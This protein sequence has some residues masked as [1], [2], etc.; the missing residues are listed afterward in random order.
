MSHEG[1]NHP[2]AQ[3]VSSRI[4]LL[5]EY[6]PDS[7]GDRM[8]LRLTACDPEA[9]WYE[10]RAE[11][12]QWMRNVVG[13]LHGGMCAALVDQAMGIIAFCIKP[14]EGTAPTIQLQVNYHRPLIPGEDVLIRIRVVSRTKSLISLSAE[15][16]LVSAPE[17]T[18]LTSSA[19]YFYKP[20]N[21]EHQD[22]IRVK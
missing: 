3:L 8:H 14:G 11:T 12:A 2:L 15:A 10:M 4:R 9:G 7:I 1:L 19:V 16:S 21:T 5:S 17:K 20:A 18:C 13:T 22:G 6:V